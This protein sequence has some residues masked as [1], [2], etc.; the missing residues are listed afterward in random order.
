MSAAYLHDFPQVTI[1]EIKSDMEKYNIQKDIGW[2]MRAITSS[3]LF[4]G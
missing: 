2:E 3:W 4:N 1:R